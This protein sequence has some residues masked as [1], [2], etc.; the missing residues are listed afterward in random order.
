VRA[1]LPVRA[2]GL[3][4]DT[5]RQPPAAATAPAVRA[6]RSAGMVFAADYPFMNILW[7]MVV[8]ILGDVFRRRDIGG[9]T[10]AAWCIFMIVA[11]FL[12]ALVYLIAQHDGMARRNIEQ[13]RG[14]EARLDERI[15]SVARSDGGPASELAQAADLR[16]RGAISAEEYEELKDRVLASP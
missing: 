2:G 3:T 14:V 5:T 11:P 12:G 16:D 13:A 15:R 6:D 1:A 10:K 9:W 4:I 8:I 7:S